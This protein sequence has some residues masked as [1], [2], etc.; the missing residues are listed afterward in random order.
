LRRITYQTI[1]LLIVFLALVLGGC[2]D[3]DEEKGQRLLHQA[4]TLIEQDD[5]VMAEAVLTDLLAQYPSSQAAAKGRKQLQAITD[6]RKEKANLGFSKILNSYMQVLDGY[7]AMYSEYPRSI[8]TLDESDYFFDSSYLNE[9]T[10]EEYR[11]YLLLQDSGSGYRLWCV[12]TQLNRG[13]A[14]DTGDKKMLPFEPVEILE[15]LKARF[16]AEAWDARVVTLS[17]I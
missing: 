10:P 16:H 12:N 14:V 15:E 13:Y 6:L 11:V 2:G 7:R 8:A 4:E 9:I 3:S 1:F 5:D 17:P